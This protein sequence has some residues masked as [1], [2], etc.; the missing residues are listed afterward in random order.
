MEDRQ[1]ADMGSGVQDGKKVTIYGVRCEGRKGDGHSV[2]NERQNGNFV[3]SYSGLPWMHKENDSISWFVDN[4][5]KPMTK[6]LVMV[7]F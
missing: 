1:S 7:D 3:S 6:S 2:T 5:P 4:L